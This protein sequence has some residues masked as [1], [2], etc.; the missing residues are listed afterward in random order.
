MKQITVETSCGHKE[1]QFVG[2]PDL[3]AH[4]R[5]CAKKSFVC[6]KCWAAGKRSTVYELLDQLRTPQ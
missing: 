4:I 2:N 6:A 1:T 5:Y 3:E